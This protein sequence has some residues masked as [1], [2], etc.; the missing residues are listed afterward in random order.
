MTCAPN[1]PR[2]K[3]SVPVTWT[4]TPIGGNGSYTYAW[5]LAPDYTG[6]LQTKYTTS[7]PV[8]K[9]T[10]VG[11]KTAKVNLKSGSETTSAYCG[12]YVE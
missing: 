11:T 3:R 8:K 2:V 10:R 7:Q 1:A 9:Y 6:D 12:V 4:A 5:E